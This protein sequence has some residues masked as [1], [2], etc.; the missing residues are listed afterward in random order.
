[1]QGS[2]KRRDDGDSLAVMPLWEQVAHI[3]TSEVESL[4]IGTR[5]P[6]EA[7][8]CSRFSVSRATLRQALANVQSQGLI[9]SKPGLGWFRADGSAN[10]GEEVSSPVFEPAGKIMSFSDMARSRQLV[11]D[12]VIL[13]R[14]VHRAS[15]TEAEAL[16]VAPGA[17]I[18]LLKRLRRLSGLTV[19]LDVSLVPLSVLPRAMSI[20]FST[21]SLHACFRAAGAPPT[22]A[23]TEIEA[24]VANEENSRLLDVPEGFPLL[25]VQQAFFDARGRAIERAVITYRG[26]RY[27]FRARLST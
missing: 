8:Q 1:M 15:F 22:T 6:S 25:S 21:A 27:R 13:E 19:A 3:L 11:P 9:E 7:E 26:D 18:L 4:E 24:I 23:H 10:T 14:R 17:D 20:D 16:Q 5:L 12:S 2:V